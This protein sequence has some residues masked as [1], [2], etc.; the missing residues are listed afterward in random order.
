MLNTRTNKHQVRFALLLAVFCALGPFTVDMYLSS[1]P[2]IMRFFETN[3]SMV[4]ASLTSALIGLSLGQIV[5]GPLSD[6]YGRR[7]PLLFSMIL[8]FLSSAGCAISPYV[9]IFIILRFIQGF[10]ASAGL[11]IARAIVRD[12]YNGTELTKFFALLT[13]IT[14]VTPLLS[15]LAGIAV[16]SFTSW[17]GVFIVTAIIGIYLTIITFWR[18]KETLPVEQRV[19]SN[20]NGLLKNYKTLLQDRKFIGYG[21]ASGFLFAGCFAYISG[22]PFIYQTIY[23]V[24]PQVFSILFALNG[25]SLMIGAQVVKLQAGRM[26]SHTIFLIGLSSS[27]VASLFVLIVVI[28]HGPLAALVISLFLF[29]VSLGSVGPISFTLAIESQGHIAGS[30][31]ALLGILPFLLGS[32]TSPLVG[33]AGEY[34]ALPLGIIIFITSFLAVFF[35]VVLIKNGK[36]VPSSKE[37][38]VD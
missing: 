27:F 21:L 22:S 17:I 16:I 15:P 32:I 30:A 1:F 37:I 4:Q 25:V 18:M 2:E 12:T 38:N 33:I 14:S 24:S 28:S 29:N 26:T 31:S 23:G 35:N 10:S 5:I 7:R 13:T 6:V 20:F 11:V 9:E 8:F 36:T 3:A 34:S 19:S